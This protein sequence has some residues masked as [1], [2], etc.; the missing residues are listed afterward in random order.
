MYFTQQ[1]ISNP[2]G[3]FV[4]KPFFSLCLSITLINRCFQRSQI[5]FGLLHV[6]TS[7]QSFIRRSRK[8]SNFVEIFELSN[9]N[10]FMK[11]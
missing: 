2:G 3:A 1:L 9:F 11:T 10:S 6:A 5:S 7:L 8:K 4:F